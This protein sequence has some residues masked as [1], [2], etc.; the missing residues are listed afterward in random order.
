MTSTAGERFEPNEYKTGFSF[1]G[2]YTCMES[3]DQSAALW[4]G[5]GETGAIDIYSC[6]TGELLTTLPPRADAGSTAPSD[7]VSIANSRRSSRSHFGLRQTTVTPLKPSAMMATRTHMWVGYDNGT[8]SIFDHLLLTCITEGRFHARPIIRV[9][10][11]ADGTVVSATDDSTLVHWDVEERNFEAIIR[12]Q[13]G[14]GVVSSELICMIAVTRDAHV[15]CGYADG[16]ILSID[17]DTG[18]PLSVFSGHQGRVTAM[19]MFG[20]MIFSAAEDGTVCV[21]SSSPHSSMSHQGNGKLLKRIIVSPCV[22]S[23]KLDHLTKSL[24]VAYANGL[25]QRWSANPD[26]DF[27]VEEVVRDGMIHESDSLNADPLQVTGLVSLGVAQTLQVLSLSTNG[28]NKVWYGHRNVVEENL[29]ASISAINEVI[30]EDARDTAAWRERLTHLMQKEAERKEKYV[31]ILEQ[32]SEQKLMLRYQEQWRRRVVSRSV[33]SGGITMA[34]HL[35]NRRSF[36][37]IRRYFSAWATFYDRQQRHLRRYTLAKSL[38]EATARTRLTTL[39]R[40]W[41][42]ILVRTHVK[43]ANKQCAQIMERASQYR[44]LGMY[45]HRW[46]YWVRSRR[47]RGHGLPSAEQIRVLESKAQGQILYRAMMHW[48]DVSQHR[49]QLDARH[50]GWGRYVE[51][52]A[53]VQLT[54]RTRELFH[55][56]RRWCHRRRRMASMSAVA[57]LRAQQMNI[58]HQHCYFMRWSQFMHAA[59]LD[60]NMKAMADVEAKL[61]AAESSHDSDIFEKLQLRKRIDQLIEQQ[62]GE[63]WHLKNDQA[64]LQR[65]QMSC[66]TMRQSE[67]H[68]QFSGA[69]AKTI[70]ALPTSIPVGAGPIAS[71][72]PFYHSLIDQQ[73]LS[74]AVLSQMPLAEGSAHAMMQ[75]KGNVLNTYTDLALFRQVKERRQAGV[76][77]TT[78]FSES[79]SEVKRLVVSTVKGPMGA[80]GRCRWPLCLEALDSIPLHHCT[81]VLNAIKTM[82]VA[83]DLITPEELLQVEGAAMGVVSNADWILLLARACYVRRKPLLP[84]NNRT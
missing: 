66:D 47:H 17:V 51:V 71:R 19:V 41:Q 32:L 81:S 1:Q 35:S 58:H 30:G 53:R 54:R 25:L 75:L 83:Y 27:G 8:V 77:A 33:T 79:F 20:E 78:I 6:V 52:L 69:S 14:V 50:T 80:G 76:S 48:K 82:I 12:I 72:A 65:L 45:F 70:E 23:L 7:M 67:E 4:A 62:E 44:A 29:S 24:W 11:L 57:T 49:N 28:A 46:C 60:R 13:A 31:G 56:W 63:E 84:V 74:P 2:R 5:S 73:R 64:Q 16:T 42:L 39:F 38:A 36:S 22:R 55:L 26:D 68:P 34:V 10:E 9:V 21:W 40:R 61:R 37:L 3:A 18:N 15:L 59:R 43:Q